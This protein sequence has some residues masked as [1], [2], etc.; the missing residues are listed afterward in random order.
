MSSNIQSLL[1]ELQQPTRMRLNPVIMASLRDH[2]K[3]RA[4]V[5]SVLVANGKFAV[6]PI[7]GA[8]SLATQNNRQSTRK[9]STFSAGTEHIATKLNKELL[10]GE[11]YPILTTALGLAT[12]AISG[13]AGLFFAVATTGLTVANTTNKVLA[14]PGDEIWHLEEI[15]RVGNKATYVSAFFIVDPYRKQAPN[16]GWLIHEEREELILS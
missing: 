12:G 1:S 5:E 16:K 3:P 9:V 2:T 14:R 7:K 15:G 4:L 8:A 11:S 6:K 10:G 13:G